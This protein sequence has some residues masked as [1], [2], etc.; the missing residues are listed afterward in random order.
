MDIVLK[1]PNLRKVGVSPWA[2]EE[3]MSERLGSNYV[4]ARKPNPANVAIKTDPDVIR[5]ETE[6][7]VKLCQ[8]YGC[9]VEF[10]LKDISTVSHRPE[11]LIVWAKTVSDVL[12]Y[13][14]GD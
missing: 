1:I 14:Y 8:K 7:T 4:Y 6:S 12:D 11:N 10:V 9:P 5:R 2:K 3:V 13:Y